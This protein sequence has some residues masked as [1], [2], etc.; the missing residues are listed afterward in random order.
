MRK[1]IWLL[2]VLFLVM[3]AGCVSQTEQTIMPD[4]DDIFE[5]TAEAS[6]TPT[7]EPEVTL[8]TPTPTAKASDKPEPTPKPEESVAGLTITL[9]N[10]PLTFTLGMT[11]DEAEHLLDDAKVN[12]IHQ[13]DLST[14][15]GWSGYSLRI[16]DHGVLTFDIHNKQLHEIEIEYAK[17]TK[18]NLGLSFDSGKCGM[19]QALGTDYTS[20]EDT[21]FEYNEGGNYTEVVIVLDRIS[22]YCVSKYS[23]K[24]YGNTSNVGSVVVFGNDGERGILHIGMECRDALNLLKGLGIKSKE[25]EYITDQYNPILKNCQM[26]KANGTMLNLNGYGDCFELTVLNQKTPEGLLIGDPAERISKLYGKPNKKY[27]LTNGNQ[28]YEY[29]RRNNFFFVDIVYPDSLS[30]SGDTQVKCWGYS[31]YRADTLWG[32]E[33]KPPITAPGGLTMVEQP[34]YAPF[35][36][37]LDHDGDNEKITLTV[38]KL[39]YDLLL[40]VTDGDDVKTVEVGRNQP[41]VYY[42]TNS[43]GELAAMLSYDAASDDYVT[44]IYTFE[45]ITPV[46]KSELLGLVTAVDT[47]SITMFDYVFVLGTWLANAKYT[48]NEDF[49][50][51]SAGAGLW[52]I[53][54]KEWEGRALTAAKE[55]PVKILKD[56][57]YVEDTLPIGTKL[58]PTVTDRKSFVLFETE[59]GR[60]G[61]I[62]FERREGFLYIDGIED[63]EMFRNIMYCG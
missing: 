29:I 41:S 12:Y 49:T 63:G 47:D 58:W 26:I 21:I 11:M 56:G 5:P 53:D 18:T 57:E 33:V 15:R 37:D 50:T 55:V 40:H 19:E 30:D 62:E 34:Y 4:E 51:T 3:T 45:G 13:E 10:K 31:R 39:S 27:W 48:I 46:E 32:E 61:R 9:N 44:I 7:P 2:M 60:K 14:R 52:Y 24:Q 54:P 38:E 25:W 23:R 35:L 22:S 36:F 59:D 6:E 17:T 8:P 28:R 43:K 1:T 20:I 16:I 42:Y